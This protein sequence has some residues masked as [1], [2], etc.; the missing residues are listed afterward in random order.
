MGAAAQG[1]Y[2]IGVDQDEYLTTFGNGSVT[3]AD[4]LLSSAMKRVDVAVYTAIKNAVMDTW[5]GGNLLLEAANDG[6]GLAPFHDTDAAIPQEVKDRLAEIAQGMK[7]GTIQ[8][9][10][11]L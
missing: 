11:E 8:T 7:A 2:V 4:K 3:G 6:V 9:G 10:V 1:V 5:Q